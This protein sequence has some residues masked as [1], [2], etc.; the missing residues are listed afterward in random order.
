MDEKIKTEIT[1]LL[2]KS[3]ITEFYKKLIQFVKDFCKPT[4]DDIFLIS[5]DAGFVGNANK[6][7]I[8]KFKVLNAMFN[9]FDNCNILPETFFHKISIDENDPNLD[10]ILNFWRITTRQTE[11]EKILGFPLT[12]YSNSSISSIMK[13]SKKYHLYFLKNPEKKLTSFYSTITSENDDIYSEIFQKLLIFYRLYKDGAVSENYIF[14]EIT[15]NMEV[16]TTFCIQDL[17]FTIPLKKI[18]ILSPKTKLTFSSELSQSEYFDYLEKDEIKL[19]KDLNCETFIEMF[20]KNFHKYFQSSFYNTKNISAISEVSRQ[21]SFLKEGK[22]YI[23]KH[24][25]S[26]NYIYTIILSKNETHLSVMF[27]YDSTIKNTFSSSIRVFST[28]EIKEYMFTDPNFLPMY[29]EY[30]ITGV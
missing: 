25:D 16:K 18:I 2:T 10:K 4:A 29:A 15:N 14:E 23:S 17:Y 9:R 3:S 22:L 11:L 21:E 12:V 30:I 28:N 24:K 26:K 13:N 8:K 7:R 5:Q 1:E 19:L 27:L 20:V 6:E